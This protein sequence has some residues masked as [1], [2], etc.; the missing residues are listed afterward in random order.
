[1]TGVERESEE[2]VSEKRKRESKVAHCRGLWTSIMKVHGITFVTLF[3][4]K[5]LIKRI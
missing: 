1:M 5:K 4:K 2:G 3:L